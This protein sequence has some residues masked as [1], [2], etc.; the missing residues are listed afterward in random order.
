MVNEEEENRIKGLELIV[1]FNYG[2]CLEKK[3][4]WESAKAIYEKILEKNHYYLDATVRLAW[5]WYNLGNYG[6]MV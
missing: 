2:M 5:V 6:K 3:C 1:L 4:H